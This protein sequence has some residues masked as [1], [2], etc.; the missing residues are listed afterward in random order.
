MMGPK[1]KPLNTVESALLL[2]VTFKAIPALDDKPALFQWRHPVKSHPRS[3]A[4]YGVDEAARDAL[5]TLRH[6]SPFE[7][8]VRMASRKRKVKQAL[9]ELARLFP[10]GRR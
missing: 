8:E 6:I 9:P 2:G 3:V 4:F 10:G 5:E 1:T 7:M